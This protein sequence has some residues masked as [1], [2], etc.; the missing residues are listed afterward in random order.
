MS[1]NPVEYI[2]KPKKPDPEAQV[3]TREEE[4]RLIAVSD[5]LAARNIR[6]LTASGMRA[7]SEGLELRHG[8]VI[9]TGS[10]PA[11]LLDKTK[12]QKA[13]S[14]PLN[15]EL[16]EAIDAFTNALRS[17][18]LRRD[19]KAV[20][21]PEPPVMCDPD[22]KQQ[23]RHVVSRA[24]ISAFDRA[25]TPRIRGSALNILRHTFGSRLAEA[26]LSLGTI[27]TL[28]GNSAAIAERHYIRFSP[29]HLQAAMAK[30]G[31]GLEQATEI[32]TD[33]ITAANPL[34]RGKTEPRN[35]L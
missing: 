19:I 31:G 1:S 12:T 27:A 13:R 33:P 15:Q 34:K 30:V 20:R 26:G 6:F 4:Q 18:I 16:E 7:G 29:G 11:I 25:G 21:A 14:I 3:V 23:D 28:M 2:D 35:T 17:D 5:P 10:S 8:R 22:G 24:V 32:A 9:R